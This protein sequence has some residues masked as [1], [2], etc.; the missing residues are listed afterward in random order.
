MYDMFDDVTDAFASLVST[1]QKEFSWN[2]EK[3]A[4]RHERRMAQSFQERM[5]NTAY[6]RSVKDLEAAGLNRVLAA[7]GP[8]ASTPSSSGAPTPKKENQ[9]LL[10]DALTGASIQSAKATSSAAQAQ[11]EKLSAEAA[12]IRKELPKASVQEKIYQAADEIVGKTLNTAKRV[13][14]QVKESYNK[15]MNKAVNI[16]KKSKGKPQIIDNK[17]KR[18]Y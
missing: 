11:A 1:A 12:L 2:R 7:G 17:F 4:A 18:A 13:G 6:Q 3:K 5:S 14:S 10:G 9:D 15:A 8:G 16:E